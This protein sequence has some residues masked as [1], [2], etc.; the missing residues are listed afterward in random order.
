MA[1]LIVG[2]INPGS[3]DYQNKNRSKNCRQQEQLEC[4]CQ[5]PHPANPPTNPY[6]LV[7]Q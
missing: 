3:P 5:A 6:V 7:G 2:W 1:E 4:G